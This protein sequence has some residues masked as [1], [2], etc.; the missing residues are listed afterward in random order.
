MKS[1]YL[2]VIWMG[3]IKWTLVVTESALQQF[4]QEVMEING[5]QMIELEGYIDSFDREQIH[6]VFDKEKID[7]WQS[8]RVKLEDLVSLGIR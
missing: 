4:Q 5:L 8:S 2:L 1:F 3:E 7:S 6:C